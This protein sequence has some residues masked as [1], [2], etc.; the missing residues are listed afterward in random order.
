MNYATSVCLIN[1]KENDLYEYEIHLL[2]TTR[3]PWNR[4]QSKE[5]NWVDNGKVDGERGVVVVRLTTTSYCARYAIPP[6]CVR[7]CDQEWDCMRGKGF[8]ALFS[9]SLNEFV[10]APDSD[11]VV[12]PAAGWDML[13]IEIS[14]QLPGPLLVVEIPASQ[15]YRIDVSSS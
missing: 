8:G 14:F 15:P 9:G 7:V 13:E 3:F 11:I 2:H 1:F 4:K 5:L 10:Y 6:T 12:V